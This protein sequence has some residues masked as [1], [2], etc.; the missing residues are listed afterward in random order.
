[1]LAL[2]VRSLAGRERAGGAAR[3]HERLVVFA[4]EA[5]QR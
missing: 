4:R 3:E 2:A 1:M 5:E